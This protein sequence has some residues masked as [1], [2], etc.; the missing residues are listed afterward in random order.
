MV[1]ITFTVWPSRRSPG[2]S[3]KVIVAPY[4]TLRPDVVPT[5]SIWLTAPAAAGG[6]A[7]RLGHHASTTN[8][9]NAS[10]A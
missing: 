6:F 9:P 4:F 2:G 5:G 10:T 1:T 7:A 8:A 3:T